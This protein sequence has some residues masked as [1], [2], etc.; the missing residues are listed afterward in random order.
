MTGAVDDTE[1]VGVGFGAVT[2]PLVAMRRSSAGKSTF[3]GAAE[4]LSAGGCAE[5]GQTPAGRSAGAVAPADALNA[6]EG[7]GYIPGSTVGVTTNH[8]PPTF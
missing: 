3:G 7:P 4:R 8:F 6:S 5:S 2:A 1:G